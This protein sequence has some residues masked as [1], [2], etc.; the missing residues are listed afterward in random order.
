LKDIRRDAVEEEEKVE[1]VD[2]HGDTAGDDD[3]ATKGVAVVMANDIDVEG[4]R[5]CCSIWRANQACGSLFSVI[6]A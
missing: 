5:L 2:E 3:I 1:T 6:D 4:G